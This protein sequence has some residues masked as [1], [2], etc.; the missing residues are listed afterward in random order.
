MRI[1][2]VNDDGCHALGIQTLARELEKAGHTAIIC[3]PDRERSAASHSFTF[4]NGI[5][6]S[7]FAENGVSGYAIGGTPADCGGLGLQLLDWNVDMVLSGINHG[8][9]MGGACIYSGTVGGA[10]EAS[11]C[12]VPAMAVSLGDYVKQV[13]FETA[14]KAAVKV[15]EWVKDRPLARGEIYNL[16]VPDVPYSELKGVRKAKLSNDFV[17]RKEYV[18]IV[19]EDGSISYKVIFDGEAVNTDPECDSVLFA[20]NWATLSVLTWNIVSG[21]EMEMPEIKL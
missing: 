16:N 2:L 21:N 9:N 1:M 17:C 3:A 15:L 19:N 18:K 5:P 11:M 12:G 8:P 13:N 20:D 4:R 6:V 14:A 10:M 7:E